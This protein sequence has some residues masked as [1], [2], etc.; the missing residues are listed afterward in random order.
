MNS[1]KMPATNIK[2]TATDK[3]KGAFGSVKRSVSGL[4]SS[5]LSL[6]GALGGIGLAL[7]VR[8]FINFTKSSL[9]LADGIGKMSDR[10]GITTTAL[11]T[12]RFAG[13]QAGETFESMDNNLVKFVRNLGTVR[14]ELRQSQ[15]NLTG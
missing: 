10:L 1:K 11:Q 5:V 12:F 2:I 7:G 8:A 15:M 13:E 6:Q 9:A 14:R 3:T 4:S